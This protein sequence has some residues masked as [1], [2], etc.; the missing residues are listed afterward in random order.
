MS[1]ELRVG[2]TL[3]DELV[4]DQ[5]LRLELSRAG[6]GLL[7]ARAYAEAVFLDLHLVLFVLAPRASFTVCISPT[8]LP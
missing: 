4:F 3:D 8:R 5:D 2:R 7:E 6:L 1:T